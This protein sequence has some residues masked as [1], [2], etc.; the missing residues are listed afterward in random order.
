M[1][2]FIY[3][4]KKDCND[5]PSRILAGTLFRETN[6]DHPLHRTFVDALRL[7]SMRVYADQFEGWFEVV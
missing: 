1:A 7:C 3:R 4:L 5:A 2:D 6:S